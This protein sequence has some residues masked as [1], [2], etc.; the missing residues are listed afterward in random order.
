[1]KENN[2]N[3][4]EF[5]I[6]S[7][8]TGTNKEEALKNAVQVYN[9]WWIVDVSDKDFSMEELKEL[10]KIRAYVL[11]VAASVYVWNEKYSDALNLEEQFLYNNNIWSEAEKHIIEAYLSLLIIQG[12]TNHL[13]EIFIDKKFR[14]QFLVYEDAY[15]SLLDPGYEFESPGGKFVHVINQINNLSRLIKGE[16]CF[17]MR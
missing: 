3:P 6:N 16:A 17:K 13:K 2:K 5:C 9:T 10:L 14:E 1:M 4:V 11:A 12:Q 8:Q 7:L 15:L